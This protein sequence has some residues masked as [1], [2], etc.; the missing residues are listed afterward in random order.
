MWHYLYEA[1]TG[2][3]LSETEADAAPD[4]PVGVAV[5]S[6]DSRAEDTEMWEE[7]SKSFAPRPAK[8]L[9]DRLTDLANDPV[10]SEVWSR[11]TATQRTT[12]RNRLIRL[13]GY[14]RFRGS[15]EP[16]DLG[17]RP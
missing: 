2:R 4:V 3:L 11:L 12:L 9:V 16:V 17:D 14:R 13:L 5:L 10:L 1:G 6:R 15:G 8:V 7:A